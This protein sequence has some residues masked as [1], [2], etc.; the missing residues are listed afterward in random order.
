M[1]RVESIP[2]LTIDPDTKE[3]LITIQ[4]DEV[5]RDSAGPPPQTTGEVQMKEPTEKLLAGS[6][7]IDHEG[8]T[9]P[10]SDQNKILSITKD[11]EVDV[12]REQLT[13]TA[14]TSVRKNTVSFNRTYCNSSVANV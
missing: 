13:H 9:I 1:E 11:S 3:H 7:T 2:D 14:D 12:N 6:D 10:I 5:C 4:D 8:R